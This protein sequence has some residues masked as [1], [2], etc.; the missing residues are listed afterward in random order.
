MISP[1]ILW[2]KKIFNRLQ[3]KFKLNHAPNKPIFR[4]KLSGYK[5]C[6][7]KSYSKQNSRIKITTKLKLKFMAID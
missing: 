3:F 4:A 2:I 7:M 1:T 5:Q 6:K